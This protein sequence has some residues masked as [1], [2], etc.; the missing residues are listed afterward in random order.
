MWLVAALL[1]SAEGGLLTQ[2]ILTTSNN[3]KVKDAQ[4][5]GSHGNCSCCQ[6]KERPGGQVCLCCTT[7]LLLLLSFLTTKPDHNSPEIRS[8]FNF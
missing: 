6:H 8:S 5:M 7:Q 4:R 2:D 3:F 1:D